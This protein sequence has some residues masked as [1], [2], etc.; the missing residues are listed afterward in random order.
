MGD[1]LDKEKNLNFIPS[2]KHFELPSDLEDVSELAH[3]IKR[4]LSKAVCGDSN[5]PLDVINE[6]LNRYS[7][8]VLYTVLY[9]EDLSSLGVEAVT[10][11]IRFW[12]N[13]PVLKSDQL[14]FICLCIEYR[15]E[16]KQP[17]KIGFLGRFLQRNDDVQP[18]HE[19][20]E[21]ALDTLDFTQHK[22]LTGS[23]LPRLESIEYRHVKKW[24]DMEEADE[25]FKSA[26]IAV[27][28]IDKKIKAIYDAYESDETPIKIPMEIVE[29]N[30]L[31]IIE[32]ERQERTQ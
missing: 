22:Q 18:I 15:L 12:R 7:T 24:V 30:L 1:Y 6:T 23:P 17:R 2:V 16:S 3:E 28:E 25:Y 32:K 8:Y 5:T 31:E 13:W 4:E 14:L 11:F 29:Q 19:V 20:L 26:G 21:E 10:E 9:H 27:H